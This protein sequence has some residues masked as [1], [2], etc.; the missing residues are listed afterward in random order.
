MRAYVLRLGTHFLILLYVNVAKRFFKKI[1]S[2]L[3]FYSGLLGF[4]QINYLS[5]LGQPYLLLNVILSSS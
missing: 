5:F 2:I 1:I 4:K 3:F